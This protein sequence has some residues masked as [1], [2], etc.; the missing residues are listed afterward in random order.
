LLAEGA[1]V[2]GERRLTG[3][4]KFDD[5]FLA[6]SSAD[7]LSSRDAKRMASHGTDPADIGH[8]HIACDIGSQRR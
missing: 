4:M 1:Q 6:A 8:R 7:R 5:G 3:I 2:A